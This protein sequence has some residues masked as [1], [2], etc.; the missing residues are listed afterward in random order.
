LGFSFQGRLLQKKIM[1]GSIFMMLSL[2]AMGGEMAEKT[3]RWVLARTTRSGRLYRHLARL[4][5]A[6]AIVRSNSGPLDNRVLRLTAQGHRRLLGVGDPEAEWSRPWDGVWRIVAFDI[7]EVS[8]ARRAKLRR[9]LHEHRFGWLQNSVWISPDPVDDFRQ[10]VGET[11]FN[12]ECLA[13]FEARAA[14]GENPAALVNGAW[15]FPQLAKDYGNY[16]EVLRLR[17]DRIV[18]TAAA[19]FRWLESEHRAWRRIVRRDP[20]LPAVLLPLDYP[21]RAVWAMRLK[22][23]REFATAVGG[24]A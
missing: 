19:W 24:E 8:S 3:A 6:G 15:D 2:L 23:L 17:P 14:G 21:G 18:G 12:P 5:A 1:A 20:F 4:E 16:R 7:P 11:G 13:I 22:T 10:A 9:R